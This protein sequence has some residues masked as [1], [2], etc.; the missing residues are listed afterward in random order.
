MDLKLVDK[1]KN[2][3]KI[4][5]TNPDDTLIYP[6]ISEL[7]RDAKVEDARYI[8]GHPLL[9]KPHIIVRVSEGQP[10]AAIKRAAETLAGKYREAKEL[11][12]SNFR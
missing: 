12:E 11:F 10:Q 5:V 2:S 7:L 4:E 9:D 1:E 8:T 6:L 3:V